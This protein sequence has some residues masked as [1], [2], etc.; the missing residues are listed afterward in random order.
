LIV[1]RT[2]S[3]GW[4]PGNPG[5]AEKSPEKESP[6]FVKLG[7]DESAALRASIGAGKPVAEVDP[8]FRAP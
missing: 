2:S 7:S 3:T 6:V 8:D 4:T 5:D 1:R